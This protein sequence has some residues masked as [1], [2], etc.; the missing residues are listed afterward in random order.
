MSIRDNV[1]NLTLTKILQSVLTLQSTTERKFK[2]FRKSPLSVNLSAKCNDR[3][4]YPTAKLMSQDLW[5]LASKLDNDN[6]DDNA[7]EIVV[8][9]KLCFLITCGAVLSL[10][11]LT[12]EIKFPLPSTT[13]II[14]RVYSTIPS[15]I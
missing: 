4:A 8:F 5:H 10:F 1:E 15:H 13:Q 11:F 9:G 3:F 6:I 14:Y 2:I 7:N 12:L